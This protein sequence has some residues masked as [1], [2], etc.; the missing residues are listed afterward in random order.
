MLQKYKVI[1][2]QWTTRKWNILLDS[3]F[4]TVPCVLLS[5][6]ILNQNIVSIYWFQNSAWE[7]CGW[8]GFLNSNSAINPQFF[9]TCLI[10][11]ITAIWDL[12]YTILLIIFFINFELHV[13]LFVLNCA[14]CFK[15]VRG[16]LRECWHS[17]RDAVDSETISRRS[18]YARLASS[19]WGELSHSACFFAIAWW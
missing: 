6:C 2:I 19:I 3:V 18:D 12:T 14:R 8:F 1:H 17:S 13:N 9:R 10:I 7:N 5:V 11:I 15:Y 4:P 16:M